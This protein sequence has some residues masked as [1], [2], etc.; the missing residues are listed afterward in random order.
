[1]SKRRQKQYSKPDF[2]HP[3]LIRSSSTDWSEL[4]DRAIS[5]ASDASFDFALKCPVG[6]EL[7]VLRGQLFSLFTRVY[8]EPP[9]FEVWNQA[10]FEVY[11]QPI[12]S[13]GV[14]LAAFDHHGRLIA[15]VSALPLDRSEAKIEFASHSLPSGSWYVSDITVNPSYRGRKLGTCLVSV[16]LAVFSLRGV[17]FVTARTRV[18][19]PPATNLLISRGFSIVETI[20]SSMHNVVSSKH[21]HVLD[22]SPYAK[23]L[24]RF[25]C[26]TSS[27]VVVELIAENE[28]D[29]ED[30]TSTLSGSPTVGIACLRS[31]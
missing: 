3:T 22:L 30:I 10:D 25:S 4:F 16:L 9:R 19:V 28:S 5:P 31:V 8:A 2:S 27:S 17:P 24:R 11:Y 7:E 14:C 18:D 15:F 21:L 1:M 12:I 20:A 23:R 26:R 13:S 6:Y 29:A